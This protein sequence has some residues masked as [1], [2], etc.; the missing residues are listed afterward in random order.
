[1]KY[2]VHMLAFHEPT[3]ER[4]VEVP[5]DELV[6][7]TDHILERIFYYG[8]NDFQPQAGICSVSVGDVAE[9]N[10]TLHMVA[11]MGF[12]EITEAQMEEIKNLPREQRTLHAYKLARD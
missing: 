9:L 8:Q 7:D 12:K 10:G 3:V 1:M 5:D 11:P 4:T 2:K 6:Q